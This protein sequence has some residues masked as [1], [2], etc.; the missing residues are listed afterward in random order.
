MHLNSRD[1]TSIRY[2]AHI[3]GDAVTTAADGTVENIVTFDFCVDPDDGMM[4]YFRDESGSKSARRIG[5]AD[6]FATAYWPCTMQN[7]AMRDMAQASMV[8]SLVAM[9]PSL[10][11]IGT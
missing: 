5:L 7:C 4:G 6:F 3:P 11:V 1:R 8:I 10:V 2:S 9:S